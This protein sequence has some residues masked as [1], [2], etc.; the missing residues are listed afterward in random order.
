ME[1]IY[2]T[3]TG[4]DTVDGAIGAGV[5]VVM[6]QN[7]ADVMKVGDRINTAEYILGGSGG[8][9]LDSQVVTVVALNPDGDN[10]KEFSMSTAVG[11]A[12]PRSSTGTTSTAV[13]S[14][15]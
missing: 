3:V 10:V 1:N 13:Q 12:R 9:A 7:V 4:S 6:D 14:Y 5:K 15:R 2:P 11:L 8:H